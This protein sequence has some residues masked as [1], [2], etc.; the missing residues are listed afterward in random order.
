MKHAE[1][2]DR[3]SRL[4]DEHRQLW[5]DAFSHAR[6]DWLN[7][8]QMIVG[9]MQLRKYDKLAACVDMLKQ[10]MTEESRTSKLGSPGLVEAL[11]TVRARARS[12]AFRLAIDERFQ[13]RSGADAAELAVRSLIAGFEA[14]S[15]KGERGTE[16][17][18]ACAFSN[19]QADTAIVFTYQGAYSEGALRLTVNELKKQLRPLAPA[20]SLQASFGADEA[21]VTVRLPSASGK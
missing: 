2:Q 9:Y 6:H 7:D 18:L 5:I 21:S 11:L 1:E 20:S 10:R 14:A 12:F 4:L 13:L 17:A 15:E 3:H 8:L 19:E 16:N